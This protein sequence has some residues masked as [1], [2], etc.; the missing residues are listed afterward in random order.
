MSKKVD[1]RKFFGLAI[2]STIGTAIVSNS[3]L[4]F[5]DRENRIKINKK[6]KLHSSAVK[7]TK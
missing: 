5:F 2:I 4:R 1:R 7:R 3:P 6:V